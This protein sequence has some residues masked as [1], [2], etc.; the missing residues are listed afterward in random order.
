V[1]GSVRPAATALVLA[2]AVGVAG[3]SFLPWV[4][5]GSAHRSSYEVVEAADRLGVVSGTG[6]LA[7][8][9]WFLLPLVVAGACLAASLG[10]A[11][12]A[13]ALGG[14]AGA[15]A[16][17]LAYLVGRSPLTTGVGWTATLAAAA[18][19]LAGAALSAVGRNPG[20]VVTRERDLRRL[21]R[22]G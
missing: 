10:R 4:R 18:V 19:V 17:L 5:S 13:V 6:A 15:A 22:R 16:A 3:A 9:A 7:V 12:P 21:K 20:S 11:G 14:L 2:G 1:P 8:R